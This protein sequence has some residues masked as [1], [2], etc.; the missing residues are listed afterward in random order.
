[1]INKVD[2]ILAKNVAIASHSQSKKVKY[3]SFVALRSKKA[4]DT[5]V[6]MLLVA[7]MNSLME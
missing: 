3:T 6:V 5:S 4:F 2:L 1:M 7:S